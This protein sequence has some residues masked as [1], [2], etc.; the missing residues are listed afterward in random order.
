MGQKLFYPPNVGGWNG[1]RTWLST[2][3]MIARTNFATA[4]TD[5]QLMSTA[6][7]LE[8][9]DGLAAISESSERIGSLGNL[10]C[11][12][13]NVAEIQKFAKE[14]A[15]LEDSGDILPRGVLEFL[16]RSEAQLH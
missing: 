3:T 11:G 2:R 16:N 9:P 5:G 7:R 8:M 10:L 12:G 14:L 4:L 6:G 1:G 13:T 15:E